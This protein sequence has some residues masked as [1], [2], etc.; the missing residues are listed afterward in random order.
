MSAT[1]TRSRAPAWAVDDAS[2]MTLAS[3]ALELSGFLERAARS[4]AE[5]AGADACAIFLTV[6]SG[7]EL[8]RTAAHGLK[9]NHAG[10]T[11]VALGQGLIGRVSQGS[12]VLQAV[13]GDAA[14]R[15][16][17]DLAEL[18]GRHFGA[19][20]AAPIE[21]AGTRVGVVALYQRTAARFGRG[22]L[23]LLREV[24]VRL[25]MAIALV[26]AA[27]GANKAQA[28]SGPRHAVAGMYRGEGVS[29]GHAFGVARVLSRAPAARVLELRRLSEPDG[30]PAVGALTEILDRT[31]AQLEREQGALA[32]RLPEAAAMIFESHLM[33]LRD[34]AFVSRIQEGRD[35]GMELGR[36]I[37]EAAADFIRIFERSEHE[38]VR[39]RARDIEDLA[40]RLIRNVDAADSGADQ[41][42]EMHVIVARE[43]LPSDIL[44]IAQR[45]V[46][47]IV[48]VSGG[49]TAHV[50]LL[51]RS[52]GI[53]MVIV[54][55]GELLQVVD[56]TSMLVDGM[57]GLVLV[58]PPEAAIRAFER[59]GQ[60]AQQAR[61][62][63]RARHEVTTTRDGCRIRLMANINLLSE[64]PH[65]LELRAEG[66]GLYRTELL[67]LMRPDLPDEADQEAVYR[68]LL[69]AVGKLPVTFRTL[70]AGGDKVLAYFNSAAE[71]NP[72][73]GL[74]STRLTLKHPEVFDRQLRAI[75]RASSEREEVRIMFPMIGSLDE[76]RLARE[77]FCLC[78]RQVMDEH[79]EGHN[80]RLGMMVELPAV[81]DLME[82]FATEASFFSIGT[83]DFI[84]Y[85]LGVDRTNDRV[86]EYYC[87][88]HPAVLR[89]LQRV[90][91]AACRRNVPVSVCGEMAHD[92]RYIPFFIGIGV[93]EL[94]VDPNYLPAVQETVERFTLSEAENYARSLL[95]Q[96]TIGEV[97]TRLFN[98]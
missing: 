48:L 16:A 74:R 7:R 78:A 3:G 50:S 2:I 92:P 21:H 90:V 38:Y 87:P 43:L 66:I 88:H 11:S 14:A 52:L 63:S 30:N 26:N 96:A 28:A 10:S 45:D 64:V 44:W 12:R 4:I 49:S 57:G 41:E 46:K 24:G 80:V 71:A 51:V 91:A 36:A 55:A 42:G 68:R 1:N 9:A 18:R 89:G 62:Q 98:G 20:A 56:G 47:G 75:L 15:S 76:W 23:E 81:V 94:S 33:M 6:P 17:P 60:L 8:I 25:D 77:R 86:S 79:G 31:A 82:D 69:R 72:A 93:R 54:S 70:D 58:D 13:C 67:Y 83:N 37:A 19:V 97:A 35:A 73:L 27:A 95:K 61:T 59:R 32:E 29:H 53:P 40:L 84:Q 85:T 5:A 22:Q 34:R 65:A 39:E